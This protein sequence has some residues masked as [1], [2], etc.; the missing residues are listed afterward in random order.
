MK[1]RGISA[2][3]ATILIILIVV[4]GVG[5]VW[6]VILPLF[7]ELEYLSYSDVELNI[8]RQGFTVYDEDQNFAFVQIERGEDEV[9]MTG[10]EIGFNFNGTTKTY[11]SSNVPTSNGK[12]TYKLILQMI[13]IWGSRKM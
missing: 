1:K 11:Q 9:N 7:A 2:V 3:V 13:Q 10:I 6:K 5:I 4:V 12:Y 8:V